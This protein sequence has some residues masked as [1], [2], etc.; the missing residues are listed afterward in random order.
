MQNRPAKPPKRRSKWGGK[1]RKVANG[2]S[3][4]SYGPEGR[5]FESLMA[6]QLWRLP[7]REAAII[8]F[9]APRG[10]R[11]SCPGGKN[12]SWRA[13]VVADFVSFAATILFIIIAAHSLRRSSSQNR[14][15][16]RWLRFCFVSGGAGV[17]PIAANMSTCQRARLLRK[18]GLGIKMTKQYAGKLFGTDRAAIP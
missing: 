15:R 2:P 11:S 12:P 3:K 8:A 5:G 14:I 7:F 13:I 17:Q 18:G 9:P 6:C 4:R 16:F 1:G 10:I